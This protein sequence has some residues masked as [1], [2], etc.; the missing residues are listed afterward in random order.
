MHP[1]SG[2]LKST[3][4]KLYLEKSLRA[5]NHIVTVSETMKG[6]ILAAFPGLSITVVNNGLDACQFDAI[7]DLELQT[8]RET[9]DLPQQ[10][11]LT[12]GHLEER[13]NHI[14]LVEAMAHLRDNGRS[15]PLF[16][17][18]NDSGLKA[19]IESRIM[20]LNLQG[21]VRILSNLS[22]PAVRCMYKLA[23]LFVFPSVYEGF[24]IPI[25]EAMAAGCPMALSDTPVFREITQN[26][27]VYFNAL[28][29]A[30]IARAI[31]AV[32]SSENEC[33]RQVEY[34][35]ERVKSFSFDGLAAQIEQLYQALKV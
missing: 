4:N 16:I 5:A 18:G 14:R 17:V 34:G 8:I 11:I 2:G 12:V 20:S 31:E 28:E 3:I 15:L 24:G 22:D 35:I 29:P 27:G 10:F 6:E 23:S 32:A 9:Y 21:S 25:L 7:S 26:N 13:K 30:S 19:S 1:R 33:D